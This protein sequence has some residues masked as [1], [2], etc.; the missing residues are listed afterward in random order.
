MI[1]N[2]KEGAIKVDNKIR[3]DYA[4]PVGLMDVI[5]I[6][7]TNEQ[8]RLLYDVKGRFL[9]KTIK[10]EEAKYKLLQIKRKELG[11]NGIPYI[12]SHD[13][14]T[15]R[16]PH[17]EIHV[18]DTVKY[19]LENNKVLEWTKF[20]IGN[21]AYV[22]SGHNIG[23]VGVITG[24]DRHLGSFDIVH[25]RDSRG[26]TFATRINNVFVIGKGKK[27]WISLHKDEGIYLNALE[28]KEEGVKGTK[29]HEKAAAK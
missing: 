28:R 3:K 1:V 5:Q 20:E 19:D 2:D 12:V 13:G 7:K 26:H 15:I 29:K 27:P 21:I 23:R 9:L 11:P 4:F 18:H 22:M 17:P 10:A 16:F 24:R 25:I 8:F 6:E 14:R